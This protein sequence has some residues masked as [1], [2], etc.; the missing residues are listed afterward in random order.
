MKIEIEELV[1]ETITNKKLREN[2]KF[3]AFKKLGI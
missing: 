3:K 2:V 1:N